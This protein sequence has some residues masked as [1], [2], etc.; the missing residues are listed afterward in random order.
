M[1]GFSA[2]TGRRRAGARLLGTHKA[3]AALAPA[4][5]HALVGIGIA[6]ARLLPAPLIRRDPDGKE[7]VSGGRLPKTSL[8]GS[9]DKR[10]RSRHTASRRGRQ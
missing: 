9:S 8:G 5:A 7:T 1:T 6:A 2:P 4:S 10:V 3:G